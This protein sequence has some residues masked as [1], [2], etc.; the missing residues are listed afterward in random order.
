M[1]RLRILVA[2]DHPIYRQGLRELLEGE[3]DFEV[4]GEAGTGDEAV[5][6]AR[7][8]A[9][10]VALVDTCMP[11]IGGLAAAEQIRHHVPSCAL[12][13]L[14]TQ[15]DEAEIIEAANVGAAAL[16]AKDVQPEEM[17]RA[18]REIA[19]GEQPLNQTLLAKPVVASRVLR[20]F[21]NLALQKA[22]KVHDEAATALS[23][24]ERE[25]LEY[26]ARGSSNKEIARALKISDQ[27]VKNHITS[28]LRKLAVNDRT[29][30]VVFALRQGWIKL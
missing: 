23:S 7:T 24:R 10:D 15:E 22:R 29:Q 17:K 12:V 26:I 5:A 28:I 6:L 19:R 9:P 14:A 1:R 2:D 11:G 27:T 13:L 3:A 21:R 20:E 8:L 30:A 18:L 4:V 16:F 25:V